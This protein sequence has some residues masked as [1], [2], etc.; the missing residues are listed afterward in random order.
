MRRLL[1]LAPCVGLL[2]A[3]APLS[4]FASKNPQHDQEEIA[5][6]QAQ[7]Q[8]AEQQSTDFQAEAAQDAANSRAIAFLKSEELRQVQLTNSA[9][10]TAVQQIADGLAA[11]IRSQGDFNARNELAILQIKADAL[12]AKADA[13]VTN[14]MAIGRADEIANAQAQSQALHQLADYLTS[15]LAQFNMNNA[16]LIADNAASELEADQ[17]VEVQNAEAM[18]ANELFAADEALDAANVDVNSV[19]IAGAERGASLIAHAE[20]EL[21]NAEAIA[22]E[23]P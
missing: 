21:T 12:V 15:T 3:L 16:E 9:N 2:L 10:A 19:T 23:T 4:A 20:E 6:A 13:R 17:V 1:V 8:L 22:A 11:A 14:A 18:G 7:L 5:N